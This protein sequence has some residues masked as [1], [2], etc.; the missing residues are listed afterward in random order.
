MINILESSILLLDIDNFVK[1]YNIPKEFIY[2]YKEEP[3]D[4]KYEYL[5]TAENL[6]DLVTMISKIDI[7]D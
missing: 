5:C 7:N 4:S 2:H 6:D 1:L 3:L